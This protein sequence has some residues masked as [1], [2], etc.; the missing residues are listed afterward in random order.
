VSLDRANRSFLAFVGIALLAGAIVFCGAVGAVLLPL[1]FAPRSQWFVSSALAVVF[2]APLAV[3]VGLGIRSLGR[4]ALASYRLTRRVRRLA[5]AAPDDLKRAATHTGLAGRIVVV[6]A[7]EAFSF[8]Y[9]VFT[10][11]VAVSRSLCD[12]ASPGELRAVLE[13]ERYHVCN[14]DPLKM[15]LLRVLS[16]TLFYLPVLGSLR[17]R[18][19]AGR[20]LAADRRAVVICGRRSLAGALLKVVRG[21]D[22]SELHMAASLGG[23]ELLDARVVQLETGREPKLAAPSLSRVAASF[24]VAVILAAAYVASVSSFG[25]TAV[26]HLTGAALAEATIR[27]GL[28]CGAPFAGAGLVLYMLIAMRATRSLNAGL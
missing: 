11:R 13:H 10:P 2:M 21:P 17:A 25:L 26:Y 4:Q 7:A 18:Y 15:F 24:L 1:I 22:W 19:V 28:S 9:G 5:A 12:S 14:L 8:V 20:E 3:G 6:D 16:A 27:G 23:R